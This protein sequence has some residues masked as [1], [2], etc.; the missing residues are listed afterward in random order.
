MLIYWIIFLVILFVA[1][2][3]NDKKKAFYIAAT[4]LM[5][6]GATRGETVGLDMAVGYSEEF[7]T[8]HSNP[9]SWGQTMH[10]FEVGF[11]WIM[12]S[13]KDYISNNKM[14]F[15]H[16]L[17][18]FTFLFYC[19]TIKQYSQNGALTLFFM[20]GCA[21]YFSLY[22]TMRQQLCFSI[23]CLFLPL[24]IEK[25][26]YL[27]FTLCTIIIAL[28]FHKS[29]IILL[30]A[31]PIIKYFNTKYFSHNALIISLIISSLIGLFGTPHVVNIL[32]KY[33][34]IFAND[35]SNYAGYLLYTDNIGNY[36]VI[37]NVMNTIFAIYIVYTHRYKRDIFLI[38]YVLGVV[39]LNILTPVSWIFMRIAFTFMYF[40]IFTYTKLWYEIPMK[41]ERYLYRFMVLLYIFLMFHNRLVNDNSTDVVPYI[42]YY[43]SFI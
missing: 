20:M 25:N 34:F 26:K 19:K 22:N 29:Q 7:K 2:F 18:F 10:Q 6:L 21:Y 13:F 27:I 41:K 15:F 23:I 24:I 43:L 5:I 33:A 3:I 37:S 40:R 1:I 16:L 38:F 9:S 28:L 8:I 42:N 39:I 12:G 11:A 32:G 4:I 35:N 14:H 30:L 36:S 31:I 17:F